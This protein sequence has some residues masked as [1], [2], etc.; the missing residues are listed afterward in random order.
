MAPQYSYIGTQIQF[1]KTTTAAA[2][3]PDYF[4]IVTAG[5]LSLTAS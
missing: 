4:L 3:N 1:T 5:F 2:N